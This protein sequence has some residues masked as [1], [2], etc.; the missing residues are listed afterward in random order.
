MYV[1]V[2]KGRDSVKSFLIHYVISPISGDEDKY[3]LENEKR[4]RIEC[5]ESEIFD[6]L[7]NFYKFKIRQEK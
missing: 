4:E 6:I 3:F 1:K 2:F 7:D 5:E